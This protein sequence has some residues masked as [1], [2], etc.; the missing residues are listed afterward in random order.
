MSGRTGGVNREDSTRA[1]TAK[2]RSANAET[3]RMTAR[4]E[5]NRDNDR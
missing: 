4:E 5:G 2:A 1:G 3:S